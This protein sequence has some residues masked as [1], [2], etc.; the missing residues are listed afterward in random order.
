M[1][2]GLHLSYPGPLPAL[3]GGAHGKD[4]E[5]G[6]IPPC[7]ESESIFFAFVFIFLGPHLW[8]MEV[9]RLGITSEP[10]QRPTPQLMAT[11]YP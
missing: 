11:P 3:A 2:G 5:D 1:E 6:I 9:P 4:I 8:H 10:H 7:K